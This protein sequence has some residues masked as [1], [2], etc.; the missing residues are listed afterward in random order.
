MPPRAKCS[1][2]SM[3][4]RLTC[5]RAVKLSTRS[6]QKTGR[7]RQCRILETLYPLQCLLAQ[8]WQ[9]LRLVAHHDVYRE[10]A[11]AH[12]ALHPAPSP[13]DA[14]RYTVPS[15]FRCQS[16]TVGT[17]SASAVRVVT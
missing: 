12:H 17:V 9:H 3:I 15:R 13:P 11:Y 6:A 1:W 4:R 10:F 14:G 16:M 7:L 2:T 8:A 5:Y